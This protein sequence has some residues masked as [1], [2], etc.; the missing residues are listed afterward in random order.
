MPLKAYEPPVVS[1]TRVQR[2]LLF[3]ELAAGRRPHVGIAEVALLRL[4]QRRIARQFVPCRAAAS[5]W[6]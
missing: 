3:G 5:Y 4:G 1:L 6:S 2:L